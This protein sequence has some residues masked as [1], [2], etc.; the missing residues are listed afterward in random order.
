LGGIEMSAELP[1]EGGDESMLGGLKRPNFHTVVLSLATEDG[2]LRHPSAP[3]HAL[4]VR[5][6][7]LSSRPFNSVVV[8]AL[9]EPSF[10]RLRI[11]P[12]ACLWIEPCLDSRLLRALFFWNEFM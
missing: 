12:W 1:F 11:I 5:F 10:G 8:Q 6:C 9:T 4:L 3:S 7:S 2:D